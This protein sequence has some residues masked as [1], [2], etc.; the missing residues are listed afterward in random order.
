MNYIYCLIGLGLVSPPALWQLLLSRKRHGQNLCFL[1]SYAALRYGTRIAL[2]DGIRHL[3][4]SDQYETVLR[5]SGVI[6]KKIKNRNNAV[7]VIACR[8]TIDH[9]LTLYAIKNLGIKLIVTNAKT[10]AAELKRIAGDGYIFSSEATHLLLENAI[11]IDELSEGISNDHSKKIISKKNG[12]VVFPTSGTTGTPRLVE[13]KTGAFYWV[14][15]L[16]DLVA[17]TSIHQKQSVYISTPVS[18]MFGY[19]VL[20]FSLVLGK[21]IVTTDVKD[22]QWIAQLLQHEKVD[23]LTGVPASLYK[24]AEYLQQ[25]KHSINL[26]ISNGAPFTRLVLEKVSSV[27]TNNIFSLYGSTEASV[28]FIAD[29][30]SLNNNV[31]AL[32]APLAGVRYLLAPIPGG[33]K[34]LLI[35]SPMV[36]VKADEWIRTGDLVDNEPNLYG[37]RKSVV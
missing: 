33:G 37:D 20:L 10:S 29:Y 2:S 4:F 21:K 8:N 22:P 12:P 11:N 1:L 18:H 9:I 7:V 3:N 36:N 30:S 24:I 26:I 17:R 5:L 13:K 31:R 19:T 25:K 16:A 23:L 35:Q 27:L 14:R 34:E 6:S 32:G 28:S 15:A